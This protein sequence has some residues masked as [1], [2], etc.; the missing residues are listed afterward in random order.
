MLTFFMIKT[1]LY[2]ILTR[3]INKCLHFKMFSIGLILG[4]HECLC[5]MS[6]KRHITRIILFTMNYCLFANDDIS[7]RFIGKDDNVVL[8]LHIFVF[9]FFSGF[10]FSL[11]LF[12]FQVSTS[13]EEFFHILSL[14]QS[15]DCLQ[16][17]TTLWAKCFDW[18]KC[19]AD[20]KS[21]SWNAESL[22][23]LLETSL[24]KYLE[25]TLGEYFM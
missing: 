19:S 23:N 4:G 21:P 8:E 7:I 11:I 1:L 3:L 6:Q 2:L 22:Q 24:G 5:A 18:L 20:D 14:F 10:L 16:R 9:M 17:G 12:E 13:P 15:E 25:T